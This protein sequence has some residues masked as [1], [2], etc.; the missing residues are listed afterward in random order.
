MI[1]NPISTAPD[2][3]ASG[4]SLTVYVSRTLFNLSQ[5]IFLILLQKYLRCCT[6]LSHYDNSAKISGNMFSAEKKKTKKYLPTH[7]PHYPTPLTL[8]TLH[9][10]LT[11]PAV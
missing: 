3:T 1:V 2:Q 8:Q 9:S 10:A 4:P 7:I 11:S 5:L 6:E